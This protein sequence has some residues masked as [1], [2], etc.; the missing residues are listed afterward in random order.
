MK[1]LHLKL[2]L[3][4]LSEHRKMCMLK[5]LL[6]LSQDM[7]NINSYRPERVL[8]TAPRLPSRLGF[9]LALQGF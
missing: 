6:K 2:N 1:N 9:A 3:K 7:E 5:L 4:V 8:R